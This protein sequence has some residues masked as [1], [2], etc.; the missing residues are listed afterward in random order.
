[1]R[2]GLPYPDFAAL[3]PDYGLP[4]YL[5]LCGGSFARAARG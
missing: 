5:E 3:N 1:M 2:T 4:A